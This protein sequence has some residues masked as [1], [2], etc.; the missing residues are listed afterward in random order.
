MPML[1]V[2]ALA[3]PWRPNAAVAAF[4]KVGRVQVSS[5]RGFISEGSFARVLHRNWRLLFTNCLSCM[6]DH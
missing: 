6:V 4:G 5:L 1:R 3:L 2:G